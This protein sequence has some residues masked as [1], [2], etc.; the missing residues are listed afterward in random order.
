MTKEPAAIVGSITAA[1]AAIIALLVAFGANVSDEQAQAVL[2]V[3]AVLAPAI[4]AFVIRQNVFASKTVDRVETAAYN[5]G[6]AGN[7]PPP[8][9]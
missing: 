6:V 4:A 7:K 9:R 2:G 1:V 3:V 5:D 8:P